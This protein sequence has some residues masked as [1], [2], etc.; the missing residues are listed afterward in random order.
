MRPAAEFSGCDLISTMP[1][2]E[3]ISFTTLPFFL[4]IMAYIN[5]FFSSFKPAAYYLV[6]TPKLVDSFNNLLLTQ[7][8]LTIHKFNNNTKSMLRY[9]YIDKKYRRLEIS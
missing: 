1:S 2:L 6:G 5:S 4:Y 3:S 8:E 7:R 9:K